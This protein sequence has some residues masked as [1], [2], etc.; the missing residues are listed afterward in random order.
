MLNKAH[1]VNDPKCDVLLSECYV[2]DV[3][4]L[5]HMDIKLHQ[6]NY[7]FNEWLFV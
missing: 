2:N 3:T 4:D 1:K 6:L 7:D 5:V